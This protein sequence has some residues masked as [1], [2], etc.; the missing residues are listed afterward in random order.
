MAE[1][2]RLLAS[3]SRGDIWERHFRGWR[4][5]HRL[6]RSR[7]SLPPTTRPACH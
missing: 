4:S 3:P 2:E 1:L 5:T 7:R 6:L